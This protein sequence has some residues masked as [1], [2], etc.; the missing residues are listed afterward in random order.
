MKLCNSL[1]LRAYALLVAV[2]VAAP[3]VADDIDI[4][5]G[6]GGAEPANVLI[7]LDSSANWSS[8]IPVGKCFYKEDRTLT[9]SGPAT[10]AEG[11][12]MAIEQCALYNLIDSLP[13][14]DSDPDT[15]FFN[16]GFMLFNES[17]A[18]ISGGYPRVALQPLTKD[19]KKNLKEQIAK[20]DINDDKGN[21]A[22]FAK[23]L[24]EAYLYLT[25]DK[26]FVGT[27]GDKWDENATVDKSATGNYLN[28]GGNGCGK[29]YV[30]FIGNGAP[31]ENTNN[32]AYDLLVDLTADMSASDQTKYR[33]KITYP[34]SIV[35]NSDQ[36]NWADEFARFMYASDVSS[37]D[38]RQ[39]I[40]TYSVAVIG[41][42]NDGRYPNFMDSIAYYGGSA[43]AIRADKADTLEEE[44]K[45]I[46]YNI[47]AVSSVFASASLPISVNA[48]GTYLNQIFMGMFLPDEQARP[49]WNGNLKQYQFVFDQVTNSLYLADK[50]KNS[51]INE[52]TGFISPNAVS[53]WTSSSDFWKND[54]S[55]IP[56][57]ISD[58]PDGAI[59]AKGAAAQMLRNDFSTDAMRNGRN[60][61][62]CLACSAN[63]AL[64]ASPKNRFVTS[65]SDL[66]ASLGV[67]DPDALIEWVRG[68]DNIVL[69]EKGP[70]GTVTVRPSV[71]GDVLHS[72]PAAVN[73]GG[74]IGVIV[75]YG[76]NDG[77]LH[78]LVG[79]QTGT[80]AGQT[81]WS[82]IPTEHLGTLKRLRDN[83][84]KVAFPNLDGL[85]I[86]PTPTKRDY[87]V[88]GPI[89]VY[90]K[91]DASGNIEKVYL[92]VGMRRGG[93]FMYA[94]D[95]TTPATPK[96]L[97]KLST[98]SEP[99]L[100]QTWSEPQVTK[101]KGYTDLSGNPI[102]VLI[103]GGGYD[104]VAEDSTTPGTTTMGNFVLVV[105]AFTGAVVKRLDAGDRSMPA[106]VSLVDSDSDGFTDRGYA[107]DLG[108]NIY[109]LDFEI[110]DGVALQT[111]KDSWTLNLLADMSSSGGKKFFFAPDVVVTR[112]YTAVMVGSGDREKP[113]LNATSDYFYMVLDRY[114]TKGL[115]AGYEKVGFGDLQEG[116]SLTDFAST[117]GCYIKLDTAGEKV[118]NAP[119]T[120]GGI[121][122]FATNMPIPSSPSSCSS[123]LGLAKTYQ[124]PLLCRTPTVVE[125]NGGGLPPSPV[126]GIVQVP[127]TNPDGTTDMRQV[128]FI[129]GSGA[130]GSPIEGEKVKLPV[131]PKRTRRYWFNETGE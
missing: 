65:N 44:L 104:A 59:V 14:Y 35:T 22:A 4:Y 120:I 40:V 89:S 5:A 12:K 86:V 96:F 30:I 15:V 121:T 72:R 70:G 95:V 100:G 107:V 125:L 55:G 97:W 10:N 83:S 64:S 13:P 16:V 42:A 23:S 90:Q 38:G 74:S 109:R 92:Y 117:K 18:S 126:A 19:A 50:N 47:Q 88:D 78:A 39:P 110:N 119:L 57:S 82:F 111:D 108:G 94:F 75:F 71:H 43:K 8:S 103:M 51:A 41:A 84:P 34:T 130:N 76:A 67:L 28:P 20:L 62:T 101:L 29:N 124:V 24:Y 127:Y 129:I 114:P 56:E 37:K 32:T 63:T 33:T 48:R 113:L 123:N 85:A 79:N 46:F 122:Y 87:F 1:W 58:S 9:T 25:G 60:V 6:G 3:A 31:G 93:R 26:P 128:P 21:N 77:M 116:D 105:D 17:P 53:F 52:A 68:T 2:F 80:G 49:R 36:A 91:V 106:D 102:P 115:P 7:V 112:D 81:L 73:Y 131:S 118:V 27:S 61:Y 45:K 54:P 66:D 98:G 11:K 99:D 69:D